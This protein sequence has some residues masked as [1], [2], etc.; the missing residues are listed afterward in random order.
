ML[1]DVAVTRDCTASFVWLKKLQAAAE[2]TL[3]EPKAELAQCYDSTWLAMEKIDVVS[4]DVDGLN[5]VRK[6]LATNRLRL[7]TRWDDKRHDAK[8][9]ATLRFDRGS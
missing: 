7:L 9:Y 4:A 3:E 1:F 8:L 2:K 5:D 6:C